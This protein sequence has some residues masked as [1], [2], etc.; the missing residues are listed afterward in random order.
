M[1]PI[2][3]TYTPADD[4]T[5]GFKTGATGAGPFT[6][7]TTSP[8]DGLAHLV[9]LTSTANLSAISM[10]LTGT[11]AEGRAQTEVV[12]GPNNTTVYGT[13][14][15]ATLTSVSASATLGANT[16]NVGFKDESVSPALPVSWRTNP[17]ELGMAFDVSG[18]V[19]Y[20]VQHCFENVLD[21]NLTP[22][23]F[24]WFDH[25]TLTTQTTDQDG[26]YD[27]AIMAIR[28]KFNSLTAGGSLK[29]MVLQGTN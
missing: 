2:N 28:I 20:T 29:A 18:T 6:M 26:N 19:N 4:S 9:S 11:D 14:Y 5:T 7:T 1:R 23:T 10:T 27:F 3:K 8:G 16:M 15:F 22:S 24:T 17:F 13:K 25:E 21:P 12:T